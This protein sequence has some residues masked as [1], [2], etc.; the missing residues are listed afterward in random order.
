M[1]ALASKKSALEKLSKPG[2]SEVSKGELVGKIVRIVTDT[3]HLCGHLVEVS[4]QAAGKIVGQ[5]VFRN[6]LKDFVS[7]K[8]PRHVSID[9]KLVPEVEKN[10][11]PDPQPCK[12]MKFKDEERAE[13]ELLF[14]PNEVKDHGSL[15][16]D[17]RF[18]AIHLDMFWGFLTRDLT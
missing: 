4:G 3:S 9:E 14:D 13:M 17:H 7:D 10:K 15:D 1:V 6:S 11:A 12:A 2:P 8:A 16:K 5:I 18:A